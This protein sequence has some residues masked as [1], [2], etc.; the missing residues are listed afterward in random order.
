[1][2]SIVF[3][4]SFTESIYDA[5]GRD[6][7]N[8]FLQ[9]ADKDCGILLYC[10]GFV[11]NDLPSDDRVIIRRIEDEPWLSKW[12]TDNVE[13]IPVCYGG[14]YEGS[15]MSMWNRKS[16]LWFRKAVAWV[17]AYRSLKKETIMVWLDAD[18]LVL[19]KI[20][21]NT[22]RRLM[23]GDVHHIIY[24]CGQ[25]RKR[26]SGVETGVFALKR[27]KACDAF[28]NKY[29]EIY[30]TSCK[31][32][33][34]LDRWDD[35]YVFKMAL[36]KLTKG[37]FYENKHS[38]EGGAIALDLTTRASSEPL[39]FS[40]LRK[41][42]VHHKGFHRSLNVDGLNIPDKYYSRMMKYKKERENLSRDRE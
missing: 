37:N 2:S 28:V 35:G 14:K 24:C 1:M 30:N 38:L 19:H 41:Y 27:T 23:G 13:N 33:S 22:F 29:V 11:P 4:T 16:S 9:H 36:K 32:F 15:E 7:V 12:L 6:L 18:V 3:V 21:M 26:E 34:R 8:S 25:L 17:S 5:S 39:N 10:E 40:P 20:S 42:F 31:D